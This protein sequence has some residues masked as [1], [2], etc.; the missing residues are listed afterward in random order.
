MIIQK[1]DFTWIINGRTMMLIFWTAL[2]LLHIL[3]DTVLEK[4]LRLSV[5]VLEIKG[6]RVQFWQQ[7]KNQEAYY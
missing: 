7:G 5:R 2:G 6:R 3:I 4:Q 1:I